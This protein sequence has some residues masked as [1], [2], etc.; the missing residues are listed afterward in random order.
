M[1]GKRKAPYKEIKCIL[2]WLKVHLAFSVTCY[3]GRPGGSAVKNLP[4]SGGDMGDMSSTPGLGRSLEEEMVTHSSILA[5]KILWTEELGRIQSLGSQRVGH[6]EQ[7]N[8]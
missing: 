7:S 2:D 3:Q 6:D 4:A 5:W 8:T 1:I